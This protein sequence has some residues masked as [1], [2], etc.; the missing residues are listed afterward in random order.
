MIAKCGKGAM[1][2]DWQVTKFLPLSAQN[3]NS[4]FTIKI[5]NA[6]INYN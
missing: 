3:F 6:F 2:S 4:N 1:D 5:K